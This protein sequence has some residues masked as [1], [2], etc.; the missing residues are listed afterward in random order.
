VQEV[1][2]GA[3]AMYLRSSKRGNGYSAHFHLVWTAV[4]AYTVSVVGLHIC[5]TFAL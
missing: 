5:M 2:E 1:G 4:H 3:G